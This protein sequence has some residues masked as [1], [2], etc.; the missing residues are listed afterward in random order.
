MVQVIVITEALV[1]AAF[2]SDIEKVETVHRVVV[3]RDK[4]FRELIIRMKQLHWNPRVC[5]AEFFIR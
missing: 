3:G 5:F 1:M 4:N 2:L